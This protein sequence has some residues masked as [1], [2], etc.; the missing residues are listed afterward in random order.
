M[1]QNQNATPGQSGASFNFSEV[2]WQKTAMLFCFYWLFRWIWPSVLPESLQTANFHMQ[3]LVCGAGGF[4][5]TLFAALGHAAGAQPK[6]G[7]K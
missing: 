1:S 3:M 7:Q 6:A 5:F 4:V 2:F